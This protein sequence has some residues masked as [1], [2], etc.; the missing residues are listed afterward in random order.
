MRQRLS[1][2]TAGQINAWEGTAGK[3]KAGEGTGNSEHTSITS[4]TIQSKNGRSKKGRDLSRTG[5][6]M[7]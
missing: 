3:S 4:G 2:M 1:L 6:D 7:T 5:R